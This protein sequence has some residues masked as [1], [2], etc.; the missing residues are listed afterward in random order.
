MNHL[1]R[2]SLAICASILLLSACGKTDEAATAT[3]AQDTTGQSCGKLT[4]ANMNWQSAE[5]LAHI[6]NIILSKG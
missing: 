5:V 2:L 4:V 1:P 3:S 6:D